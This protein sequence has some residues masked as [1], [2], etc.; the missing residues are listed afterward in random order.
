MNNRALFTSI[1]FLVVIELL[2]WDFIYISSWGLILFKIIGL[3]FFSWLWLIIAEFSLVRVKKDVSKVGVFP[4]YVLFWSNFLY[5]IVIVLFSLFNFQDANLPKR[6]FN[7]NMACSWIY[8][9]F[10]V[11]CVRSIKQWKKTKVKHDLLFRWP[12]KKK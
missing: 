3:T 5:L 6:I 1:S 11:C 10:V 4:E 2:I 9:F 12:L 7:L 8:G